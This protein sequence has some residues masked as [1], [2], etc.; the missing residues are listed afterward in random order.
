[1]SYIFS[2]RLMLSFTT[3]TVKEALLE[4]L[5]FLKKGTSNPNFCPKFFILLEFVDKQ[6]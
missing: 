4:S 5:S 6:I 1:M 3:L 2:K